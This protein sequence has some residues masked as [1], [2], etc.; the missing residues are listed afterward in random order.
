[1][2]A[3]S[4]IDLRTLFEDAQHGSEILSTILHNVAD[5]VRADGRAPEEFIVGHDNTSKEAKNQHGVNFFL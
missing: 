5:K 3:S 1:M 2:R 4:P